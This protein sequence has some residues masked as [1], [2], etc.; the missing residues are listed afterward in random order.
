MEYFL[1]EL[2]VEKIEQWGRKQAGSVVPSLV[3]PSLILYGM[4]VFDWMDTD[5]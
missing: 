2:L 1:C 3:F 4:D 5:I